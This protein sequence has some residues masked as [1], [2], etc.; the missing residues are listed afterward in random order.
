MSVLPQ[1]GT[2]VVGVQY[3]HRMTMWWTYG[4]M[5]LLQ[6]GGSGIKPMT[7]NIYFLLCVPFALH[8]WIQCVLNYFYSP[9]PFPCDNYGFNQVGSFFPFAVRGFYFSNGLDLRLT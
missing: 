6:Q 2:G 1:G 4:W 8:N 7:A 3:F 5:P 9:Q